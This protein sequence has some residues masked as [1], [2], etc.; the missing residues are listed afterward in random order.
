MEIEPIKD[1][2]NLN[3]IDRQHRIGKIAGGIL[4]VIIGSLFLAKEL[5]VIIPVWLFSWKVLLIALGLV[6]GI[7]SGF[8][9]PW[10]LVLV[11]VGSTFLISDFYPHILI[12]SIIWPVL[13]IFFGLFIIFKPRRKHHHFRHKMERRHHERY[14]HW[15]H[16]EQ[17]YT[18]SEDRLEVTTVMGGVKKQVVTKSFKGGEITNV[19]GGTEVN[20][21]QADFDGQVTLEIT[22]VFGGTKLIV[23]AHWK[24][25]SELTS[26]MGGIEDKRPIVSNTDTA[27]SESKVLILQGTVFMGGIDIHS[28]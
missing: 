11:L 4:I 22:N 15:K 3:K 2:L 18:S 8:K 12:K 19:F 9:R 6:H 20:L 16:W 14:E 25:Q 21:S 10:W 17:S 24:I 7:K 27:D 1:D 13:L 23:P 28:F 5:G 26:V